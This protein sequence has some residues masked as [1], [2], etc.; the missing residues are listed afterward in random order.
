MRLR[1]THSA[2]A[3][4][5]AADAAQYQP[6]E[7]FPLEFVHMPTTPVVD[8]AADNKHW[9]AEIERWESYL[10]IWRKQQESVAAEIESWIKAEAQQL[11][12]HAS[13]VEALKQ[14]IVDCEREMMTKSAS[15]GATSRVATLHDEQR[16]AHE[17]IKRIHH[18]LLAC[19]AILKAKPLREE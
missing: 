13:G 7:K 4:N 5:Q 9:L 2:F 18:N 1:G 14:A 19:L 15:A 17:R 3:I 16:H 12:R 11:E 6:A 8:K 10:R